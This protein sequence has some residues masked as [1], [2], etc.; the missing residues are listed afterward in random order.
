MAREYQTLE[1]RRRGEAEDCARRIAIAEND[2]ASLCEQV[3]KLEM[4]R[5]ESRLA[6]DGHIRTLETE[7]QTIQE[8]SNAI[9]GEV[10]RTI[11]RMIHVKSSK[12]RCRQVV[13]IEK[14]F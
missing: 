7:G 9:R 5:E 11:S 4:S 8:R 14:N 6:H 3:H 12:N 1:V 2:R 10:G 13:A